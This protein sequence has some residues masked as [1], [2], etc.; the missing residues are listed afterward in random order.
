MS[1]IGKLA[2]FH[3]PEK[4]KKLQVNEDINFIVFGFTRSGFEPMIYRT[5]GDHT[6]HY[7]TDAVRVQNEKGLYLLY[8]W[9]FFAG[10]KFCNFL[11][12]WARLV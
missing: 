7:T 3:L 8:K 6:N 4:V 10:G 1:L 2:G 11:P 12:N 5:R 9:G